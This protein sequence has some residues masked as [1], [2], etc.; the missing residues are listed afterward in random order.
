MKYVLFCAAMLFGGAACLLEIFK[1]SD[2]VLV[3]SMFG[4]ICAILTIYAKLEHDLN[5][6]QE[7]EK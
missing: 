5:Y 2:D 3:L 1:K 4:I 7:K 6:K